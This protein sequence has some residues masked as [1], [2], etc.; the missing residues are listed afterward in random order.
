VADKDDLGRRGEDYAAG[1]LAA[2]GYRVLVRNWR[3][4][5]GEIDLVVEQRA[6]RLGAGERPAERAISGFHDRSIANVC[7]Y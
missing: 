2:A 4:D 3:C 5:Q 6:L 1:F 7:S